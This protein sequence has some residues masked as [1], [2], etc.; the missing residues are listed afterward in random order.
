MEI[1]LF[2]GSTLS[3]S[4]RFHSWTPPPPTLLKRAWNFQKLSHLWWVGYQRKGGLNLKKGWCRN[5]FD[6]K[7]LP[8]FYY[9]TFQSHL[10]CVGEK[11]SFLCYF[12]VH[13]S[14]ELV[15]CKIL[16]QVFIVLK[17]CKLFYISN[18]FWY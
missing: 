4:C 11:W 12:L 7:G 17:H 10:L 15:I 5:G 14:F 6:E 13:Q 1:L 16:I 18:S 2:C 3:W 9:F 8:L